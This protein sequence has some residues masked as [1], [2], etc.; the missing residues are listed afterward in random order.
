METIK[1]PKAPATPKLPRATPER[2]LSHLEDGQ[3]LSQSHFACLQLTCQQA[4]SLTFDACRLQ[5][6][7][8]SGGQLPRWSLVDSELEGC[9]LANL[10]GEDS[11]M[12]RARLS[13]C[14]LSG[15]RF[16]QANWRDVE[17]TGCKLDYASFQG[18][19][20]RQV[21]L[22]EC[23]LREVEFYDCQFESLE[24]LGCN[25][26]RAS[27]LNC[28]FQQGEF[29]NCDLTGL[30]GLAHLQGVRM[31]AHDLVAIA[32]ALGRE[33]GIELIPEMENRNV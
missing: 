9:N 24:C 16:H 7:D 27:F 12:L 8:L 32:T 26:G 33:L 14:K 5:Q 2:T 30:R 29:L 6:V 4:R 20:A 23:D 15:A 28:R 1:R 31:G 17:L 18:F 22:R 11:S 19:K 13:N 25:F 10:E 3:R 21:R